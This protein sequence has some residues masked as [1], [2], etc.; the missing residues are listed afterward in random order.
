ME[1][2]GKTYCAFSLAVSSPSEADNL[3]HKKQMAGHLQDGLEKL[4]GLLLT[5]LRAVSISDCKPHQS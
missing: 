5:L 1:K 4:A 3:S 2:E